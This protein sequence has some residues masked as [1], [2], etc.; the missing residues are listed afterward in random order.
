L[1]ARQARASWRSPFAEQVYAIVKRIPRGRV[2][3][4]GTIGAAIPPPAGIDPLAYRRIRARW[5]GYAMAAAPDELP[6]QRVVN[7]A[8]GISPR[9]GFSAAWQRREL[10]REGIRFSRAGRIDL[11]RFGWSPRRA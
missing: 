2:T 7:A 11:D 1:K 6:W 10:A 3:T 4:Y 5:V 8:G 9:P